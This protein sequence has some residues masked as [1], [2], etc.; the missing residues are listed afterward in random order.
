VENGNVE[1]AT[2]FFDHAPLP[3]LVA[4]TFVVVMMMGFGGASGSAAGFA[5]ERRRGSGRK[6]R[7]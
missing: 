7:D 6:K 4:L 1:V 2:E 5:S 3:F